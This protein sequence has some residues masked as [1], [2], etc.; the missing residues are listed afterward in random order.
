MNFFD[1]KR[2]VASF[3]LSNSTGVAAEFGLGEGEDKELKSCITAFLVQDSF[4]MN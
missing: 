3:L 4:R 1:G 2:G